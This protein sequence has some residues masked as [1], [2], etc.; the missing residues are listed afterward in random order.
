[1]ESAGESM[2][3]MPG[4]Q[5]FTGMLK[6]AEGDAQQ[7]APS[8]TTDNDGA[9]VLTLTL[10]GDKAIL[11]FDGALENL[12]AN[13]QFKTDGF[14]GEVAIVHHYTDASN[15]DFVSISNAA[16]ELGRMQDGKK[17]VLNKEDKKMPADWAT[18]TVSSAGEHYKGLLNEELVNH[19]H[20]ET[21]AAGQ[22][23]VMLN[24]KGKVMLKMME[25]MNL[26]E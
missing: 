19:G 20:G 11:L 3:W 5:P 22:V 8:V 14:Q 10:S 9:K 1:M 4:D 6:L 7:L 24:G 17:S 26:T 21:R 2:M 15:Y 23:G 12:G 16:M 25:V 13:L 18:L